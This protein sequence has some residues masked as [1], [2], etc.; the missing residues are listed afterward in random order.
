MAGAG[1]ACHIATMSSRSRW[2]LPLIVF[3]VFTVVGLSLF[4]HYWLDDLA[5]GHAG[6]LAPH[7]IEE[8]T[9]AYAGGLVF[10]AV[11]WLVGRYPIEGEDRARRLALYAGFVLVAALSHTA[12]MWGS[13]EVLFPLAGLGR[14]DYGLMR[15]RFPMEFA[16][17]APN[18]VLFIA[19]VH[20]WR[21]YRQSR[22][23]EL[24]AAQLEGELNRARL[25][26]L[27][28][29]LQPHFLFNTLN[30]ISS[31]MYS[32]PARADTM[33]SRLSDLL[34]LTF[35]RAP[36]PEVPLAEELEW[37]GW[38]LELMRLRF[39]ERLTVRRVVPADL[40]QLAVP[41][42]I[43]QPL[44]ENALKHGASQRAGPAAVEI[45]AERAA[46][47]LRLA[48]LDDGPGVAGA[49]AAA[50]NGIGLANTA[51][52]LRAL[53]GDAASLTLANRPDAGL[54]ATLTLPARELPIDNR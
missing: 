29:Q 22:E 23:R 31:L 46:G 28:A 47:C 53:Y 40:L 24:R 39:G 1:S 20:G 18:I 8:L 4:A 9:G 43:L 44:V 52:R 11:V 34:R 10:L 19:L 38:Y 35:D 14:Y 33:L 42:L 26:R 2:R 25:E 5:R 32:D 6:T 50:G 16:I 48:V 27:E 36:A 51:E 37:L 21:W 49:A 54:S 12:L 7:L 15:F 30:A 3:G 41:R 13:R 45:R 17:Q